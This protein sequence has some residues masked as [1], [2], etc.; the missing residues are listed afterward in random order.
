MRAMR[1]GVLVAAVGLICGMANGVSAISVDSAHPRIVFHARTIDQVRAR[2]QNEHAVIWGTY[3]ANVTARLDNGN[4]NSYDADDYAVVYLLGGNTRF[5]DAAI[6]IAIR[7]IGENDDLAGEGGGPARS[8]IIS[9]VYDWCF[10]ALTA[11]QKS[12]IYNA[13]Y[14]NVDVEPGYQQPWF[15]RDYN[16]SYMFALA[17]DGNAAQNAAVNANIEA[18]IDQLE[19][20]FLPCLDSVTPNS[21][22]DGY[23]GIRIMTLLCF[24]DALTNS[25]DYNGPATNS[26]YYLNTGRFWAAR[27]RP[28]TKWAKLPGK[29]NTSESEPCAYFSYCGSALGDPAAQ[30]IANWMVDSED[31][32]KRDAALTFAWHDP[33]A[34]S[35]PLSALPKDFFDPIP[36]FVMSR[37][38]WTL[39]SNSEAITVGFFTGADMVTNHT[40]NHFFITRGKDNLVI[41]SGRRYHD[42][43]NHFTPY[44][45]RAVAHNTILVYDPG[46]D[47]GDYVNV[48]GDRIDVPNDGGQTGADGD[49]GARRWPECDG[50]YGYRG[51]ITKYEANDTWVWAEGDA[52]PVYSSSKARSV[53]RRWVYLRPDWVLVQDRVELARPGLPVRAVYHCIDRPTLDGELSVLEGQLSTGGVFES[54]DAR[55]VIIDRGDSSARIYWLESEGGPTK[56]RLIGGGNSAGEHWRQNFQPED[57]VTYDPNDQSF[58]FWVEGRNYPPGYFVNQGNIDNRH[59]DDADSPGDWRVEFEVLGQSV[60]EMTAL[61]HITSIGAPIADVSASPLED[62]ISIRVQ[63]GTDGFQLSLCHIGVECEGGGYI[64]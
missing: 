30:A 19:D 24:M 4:L 40:Q 23:A 62:G 49:E 50:L 47:F 18:S 37:S 13:L 58:E 17:N 20:F 53:R 32:G 45:K 10:A 38:D 55:R 29:Y 11:N 42:V 22:I 12:T 26:P 3:L 25:A 16:W 60:V 35:L 43:A 57:E 52:S 9:C 46:E 56:M 7:M 6:E 27:F 51:E 39:G 48:W 33:D 28:D 2:L 36:G 34:P 31:L 63:D 15:I 21:A 14:P 1:V 41:D 5:A 59:S 54:P 8:S 64:H 61:I 44:F